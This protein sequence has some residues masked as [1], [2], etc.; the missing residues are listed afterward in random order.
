MTNDTTTIPTKQQQ[1]VHFDK[2][3]WES[4]L[5]DAVNTTYKAM[6]VTKRNRRLTQ[7][8]IISQLLEQVCQITGAAYALI[9]KAKY[10]AVDEEHKSQKTVYLNR[11]PGETQAYL[12]SMAVSGLDFYENVKKL[13][14]NGALQFKQTGPHAIFAQS[15]LDRKPLLNNNFKPGESLP[16]GHVPLKAIFC[17]PY[18]YGTECDGVIVLANRAGGFSEAMIHPITMFGNSVAQLTRQYNRLLNKELKEER[19]IIEST[20][21]FNISP[22]L[23]IANSTSDKSPECS[24]EKLPPESPPYELPEEDDL[25][26]LKSAELSLSLFRSVQ[27]CIVIMNSKLMVTTMNR[28]A[29]KF[30]GTDSYKN[31][32]ITDFVPNNSS[33]SL[34]W[35]SLCSNNDL[36]WYK[37]KAYAKCLRNNIIESPLGGN[38]VDSANSSNRTSQIIPIFL[39]ISSFFFQTE[40]YYAIII[41]DESIKEDKKEKMKFVSFL[42][43]EIRNSIQV[44]VSA[45]QCLV[46]ESTKLQTHPIT[47]TL[48]SSIEFLSLVINDLIDVGKWESGNMKIIEGTFNLRE[49]VNKVMDMVKVYKTENKSITFSIDDNVPTFV[50]TDPTKLQQ[51]LLNLLSNACKYT[52]EGNINLFCRFKD[53]KYIQFEITDTGV[54]IDEH[55]LT[56][57]FELY[58]RKQFDISGS[59]IG[60]ALSKIFCDI[61]KCKI[62]VESKKG[63]GSRFIVSLPYKESLSPKTNSFTLSKENVVLMENKLRGK[64]VLIVDDNAMIRKLIKQ[65]LKIC[66]CDEA[67]NG[68]DAIAKCEKF[69][70]DIILMD[71]L[72]PVL[73]GYDAVHILRTELKI[74]TP[75]IVITGNSLQDEID[76]MLNVGAS[77]VLLKPVKRLELLNVMQDLIDSI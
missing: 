16:V 33:Q 71:G 50:H 15:F 17:V 69:N 9:M 18:Y 72:M 59:G 46:N 27:D 24:P 40:V 76:S 61:L 6:L 53:S 42:S 13:T 10:G 26:M 51:I 5:L 23:N 45:V 57:L 34:M 63:V 58:N 75:I 1:T 52:K 36:L 70:Y 55:E 22:N 54:G 35:E 12:E 74:N 21:T 47:N 29:R 44:I 19:K 32:H 38:G 2:E 73:N 67:E 39:S 60:L 49:K 20:N 4:E 37:G 28:S 30:F 7:F 8:T 25:E 64:K 66:S 14:S 65:M 68:R 77:K 48:Y 43:H 62:S 3:E 41:S 11:S 31:Y 56:S